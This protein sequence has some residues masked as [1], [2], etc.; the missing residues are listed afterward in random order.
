[1]DRLDLCQFY[2]HDYG[3][4]NYVAAAQHLAALQ[5]DGKILAVGA[6]NFDVARMR[7]MRDAGVAFANHQVQY[8]LLDRRPE[9]GMVA[10]CLENGIGLTPYG[11][12]A[13]GFLSDRY[14]GVGPET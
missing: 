13:G 14:L 4:K 6:T 8:S 7:E 9:N 11:A 5:A 12:I 1:M 3:N 2:W 10:Y